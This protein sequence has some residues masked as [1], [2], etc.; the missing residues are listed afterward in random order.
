MPFKFNRVGLIGKY[1]DEN[2]GP[3]IR[4]LGEY[5]LNHDVDL[6]LDEETKATASELPWPGMSRS[7]LGS[8]CD[9]IIVLGGDGTMLAAARE[10]Y[11]YAVPLVGVHLGRLGFLT[12]IRRPELFI[13]VEQILRGHYIAEERFL[14]HTRIYGPDEVID[15]GVALNDVVLHHHNVG[16]MIEFELSVAESPLSIQRSDGLIV[17]TP[18]GSTAYALS[19]GGPILSPDLD[20][21][22]LVPICP[23]TLSSRPIVIGAD[24]EIRIV[25]RPGP[26]ENAKL[27][28]DGQVVHNLRS[29]DVV[30]IHRQSQRLTLLHP[31]DYNY[32]RLLREKLH[33]G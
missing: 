8:T 5:L 12:D 32:Y 17:C 14:L 30:E 24:Q 26:Q 15:A 2:A 16:R 3:I 27:S 1:R 11:M 13:K 6:L 18:T 23:H 28:C 25:V 22:A 4:E 21:I 10:L 31:Q 7:E 20:A 29:N 9:L 19:S 33:W